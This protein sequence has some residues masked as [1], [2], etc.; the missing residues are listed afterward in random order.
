MKALAAILLLLMVATGA[1]ADVPLATAII[2]RGHAVAGTRLTYEVRI[3]TNA[4]SLLAVEVE[5]DPAQNIWSAV[6]A[7]WAEETTPACSFKR[8]RAL[9]LVD[10]GGARPA[11]VFVN[12]R[13]TSAVPAEQAAVFLIRDPRGY[14]AVET[15]TMAVTDHYTLYMPML[16]GGG[17]DLP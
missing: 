9:C 3:R 4:P 6:V 2:T 13:V 12:T 14:Q 8:N 15:V 5:L 16:Y 11:S 10:S 7:D 1:W 17:H